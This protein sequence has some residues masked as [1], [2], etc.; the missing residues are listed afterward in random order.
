MPKVLSETRQRFCAFGVS[1]RWLL[2]G[3]SSFATLAALK[4][5]RMK[6]VWD[7]LDEDWLK[8]IIIVDKANGFRARLRAVIAMKG[9]Q[10]EHNV[11]KNLN[12]HLTF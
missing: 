7:Q 4:R 12:G 11:Q 2:D 9:G 8:N 5:R 3:H 6:H 1:Q 10:I